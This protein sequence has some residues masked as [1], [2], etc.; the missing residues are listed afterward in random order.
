M[1]TGKTVSNT[2]STYSLNQIRFDH[3]NI[4]NNFYYCDLR[5]L[6]GCILN[7]VINDALY[8]VVRKSPIAAQRSLAFTIYFQGN[9]CDM[10]F[11]QNYK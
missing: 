10:D 3:K 1:L 2:I 8:E 5:R 7:L 4:N 11:S 6:T 9:P